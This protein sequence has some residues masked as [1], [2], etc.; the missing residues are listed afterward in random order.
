MPK[1]RE[2]D[3]IDFIPALPIYCCANGVEVK[4]DVLMSFYIRLGI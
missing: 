3:F 2:I 4:Y 1:H